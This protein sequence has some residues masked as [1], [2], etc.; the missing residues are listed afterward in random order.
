MAFDEIKH[1]EIDVVEVSDV[2]LFHIFHVIKIGYEFVNT[3]ITEHNI[4]GI[5]SEINA[6]HD[7]KSA[8]ETVVEP[9]HVELSIDLTEVSV[10]HIK[11][12]LELESDAVRSQ[13]VKGFR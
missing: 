5:I 7:L 13:P 2:V 8:V 12:L 3:I 6:N 1:I 11:L 4:R 9:L 10:I